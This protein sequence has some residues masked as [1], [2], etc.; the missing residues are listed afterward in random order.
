MILQNH[1]E[2]KRHLRFLVDCVVTNKGWTGYTIRT[3][4][5]GIV[6]PR[7]RRYISCG[8]C[9]KLVDEQADCKWKRTSVG[10]NYL[11]TVRHT[12]CCGKTADFRLC[13]MICVPCQRIAIF[14]T[15]HKNKRGFEFIPGREYHLDSCSEC[16][17]SKKFESLIL[18]QVAYDKLNRMKP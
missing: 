4:V 17:G 16:N 1:P 2:F 3:E 18:E 8:G 12:P 11:D 10:V 7:S 15:P 6:D 13:P 9:D 14:L 5:R